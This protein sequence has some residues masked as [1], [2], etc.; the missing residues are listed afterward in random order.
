MKPDLSH[1]KLFECHV[2]I[3]VLRK[4]DKNK[5]NAHVLKGIFVG[6]DA[7]SKTYKY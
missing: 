5:L 4:K 6:Y 2:Y 3:H 7:H 1:L